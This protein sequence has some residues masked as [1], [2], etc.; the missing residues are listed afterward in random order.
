[1]KDFKI[2]Q[3]LNKLK[4]LITSTSGSTSGDLEL[5]AHWAKYICVLCAGF[6]EF[7]L[8]QLYSEY[9]KKGASHNVHN[10]VS[11]Y[12]F[13]IQNP[14]STKFVEIAKSF[15]TEWGI[16][17]QEFVDDEGRSEAIGNIMIN[18]HLIAHGKDSQ[19]TIS[20]VKTYLSKSVEVLEFIETQC[21][22]GY[23]TITVD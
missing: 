16:A 6:L 4:A 9:A 17:L 20:K 12:L 15:K 1:M 5:Q 18:R 2:L 14:K 21:G 22:L 7:S 23:E 8:A 10:H 3:K 19:I 13:K 11:R